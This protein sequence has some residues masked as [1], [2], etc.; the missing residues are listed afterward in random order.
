MIARFR[1]ARDCPPMIDDLWRKG[2]D[3]L[4][5]MIAGK[6]VSSTEV[7]QAHLDRIAAVNPQLNAITTLL[8]ESALEAAADADR[9]TAGG[10]ALGPLHGV[11]ITVKQNID[12]VGSA[13]NQG[14]VALAD[15]LPPADSPVAERMKAAGAIPIG[16]T[17][18]PDMGL[19]L[20]TDSGL[21]GLTRNPWHPDRTTGGSSGG[22][23]SALA[24]GMSPLGLG[25]DIGGSLRNPAT[26][27]GIASI[28]PT[29]SSV[30][31]FT[32]IPV[33]D[34]GFG[35]QTMLSEG[36]M[37]RRI[38]DVRTALG[39]L[40]GRDPR[41][42]NSIPVVPPAP[43]PTDRPIRVA[44]LAEPP[45][46]TT[47]PRVAGVVR[48]AGDALVA[49]GY[50]VFDATPPR[51]EEIWSVWLGLLMADLFPVAELLLPMLSDDA[52]TFLTLG[53][54]FV[55]PL[56]LSAMLQTAMARQ[57]LMRDWAMWFAGTAD[58]LLT[59]TWTELPF[60][61]GFDISSPEASASITV[62]A[63]SV[64]PGNLLGIPSVCVPA[65]LVG[66]L[67][68]GVLVN[69]DRHRD[70]LALDVAEA[71]EAAGGRD[72]PLDPWR[73]ED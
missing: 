31:F 15:A 49:A 37:A 39:I 43:R 7:V 24:S 70:D 16:R 68:V 58:V 12:L 47:D 73:A 5:A 59:P 25:N 21:F 3:E 69:A 41:D 18:C 51:F 29:Q 8:A 67:P 66:G 65:G 54:D 1:P 48:G 2:S 34:S 14:M 60:E 72:T 6:E 46:S 28:K 33:P 9:T 26:C 13:T 53:A 36:P 56:D 55:T 4:A 61:H 44:V 45:G 22:E 17:N 71:I 38:G 20:H 30:P 11:P 10:G 32:S 40:A 62:M 64:L 57:S 19:R 50:D 35:S 52:R 23:G 42:P 27:C 63:R